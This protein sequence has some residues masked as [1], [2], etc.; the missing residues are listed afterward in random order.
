VHFVGVPGALPT[1]VF[2]AADLTPGRVFGGPTVVERMGDTIVIPPGWRGA[3]D[4]F[5][6]LAMRPAGS[7]A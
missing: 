2:E 4:E 7:A 3:V 6:M 1:P 5:G